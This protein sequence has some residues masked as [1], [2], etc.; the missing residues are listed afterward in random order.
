M[1]YVVAGV[2]SI[3]DDIAISNTEIHQNIFFMKHRVSTHLHHR[4]YTHLQ[5]IIIIIIILLLLL[6]RHYTDK[7]RMDCDSKPGFKSL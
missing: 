5:L 4:V 3:S 6:K 1:C 2:R 7:R